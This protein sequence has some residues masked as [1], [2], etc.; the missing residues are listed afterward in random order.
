MFAVTI[1][2]DS[3]TQKR[4]SVTTSN[5]SPSICNEVMEPDAMILAF[6]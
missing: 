2:S 1:L 5:F 3:G 4:K 6:F